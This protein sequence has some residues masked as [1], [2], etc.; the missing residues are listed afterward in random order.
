MGK[1]WGALNETYDIQIIKV[2][3][4]ST[5]WLAKPIFPNGFKPVENQFMACPLFAEPL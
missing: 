2:I 5:H 3:P 1:Y 4:F